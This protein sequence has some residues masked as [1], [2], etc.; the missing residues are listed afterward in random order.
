MVIL[1]VYEAKTEHM[2]RIE[3]Y[4]FVT[5]GNSEGTSFKVEMKN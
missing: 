2:G 4:R 5:D 1:K 3:K